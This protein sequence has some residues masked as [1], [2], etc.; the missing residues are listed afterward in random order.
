[1][2]SGKIQ[3]RK[4]R[5]SEALID[6][7]LDMQILMHGGSKEQAETL[8]TFPG[9]DPNMLDCVELLLEA[10][11]W[12]MEIVIEDNVGKVRNPSLADPVRLRAHQQGILLCFDSG[13]SCDIQLTVKPFIS[14][15]L[16]AE[17]VTAGGSMLPAT[18]KL[19]TVPGEGY[20]DM[21]SAES[22]PPPG[23]G[24]ELFPSKE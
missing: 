24:K 17:G 1:M 12:R 18:I 2:V 19:P 3:I 15:K 21:L 5:I 22:A 6:K 8:I 13:L 23:F 20:A 9:E 11:K 4:G 10:G 16:W 7:P 14:D